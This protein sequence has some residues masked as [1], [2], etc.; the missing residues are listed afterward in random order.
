MLAMWTNV[1]NY[2]TDSVGHLNLAYDKFMLQHELADIIN[3]V[4]GHKRVGVKPGAPVYKELYRLSDQKLIAFG[5]KHQISYAELMAKVPAIAE[6]EKL[7]NPV[8]LPLANKI[9]IAMAS[10]IVVVIGIYLSGMVCGSI[11]YLFVHG[12]RLLGR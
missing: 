3:T 6:L 2:T 11:H 5:K 9:G 8:V 10:L 1:K 12:Y 4:K 7:A